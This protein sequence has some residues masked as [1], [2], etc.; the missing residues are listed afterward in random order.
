MAETVNTP[1]GMIKDAIRLAAVKGR[2]AARNPLFRPVLL[3]SL[4]IIIVDQ[5]SKHIVLYA[6]PLGGPYCSPTTPE[7]C[8]RI[9]LSGIFD[10]TMVWN[11]GVSFG[12]FA[13]GMTSRVI[14]STLS[15]CVA[16]G[17]LIW[18]TDLK[19]RVAAIGVGLIIGGALGNA[20]DRIVY[21]AVV[22]FLDFSGLYFPYVF[23]VADAAINVGVACLAYDA[24]FGGNAKSRDRR[25]DKSL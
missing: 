23:N 15:I 24:F 10:L 18:L 14:F 6:S 16:F 8:G 19:R 11:R 9:E 25:T 2:K 3:M 20:Y 12:L 21:G 7:F 1:R 5:I 4:I 17:L 13:G 22:D